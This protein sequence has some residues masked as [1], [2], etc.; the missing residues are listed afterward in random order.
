[1]PPRKKSPIHPTSCRGLHWTWYSCWRQL[2]ESQ[3]EFTV[4]CN[5]LC[6]L[7]FVF[8]KM[9][10][11]F[12]WHWFKMPPQIS[13]ETLD[14]S[15]LDSPSK[16]ATPRA[17]APDVSTCVIFERQGKCAEFSWCAVF[18]S[19]FCQ[20]FGTECWHHT[21]LK[22]WQTVSH[23]FQ[24]WNKFLDK[25]ARV[26]ACSFWEFIIYLMGEARTYYFWT[27]RVLR[28]I[29]VSF[30]SAWNLRW[31]F[32]SSRIT[33]AGSSRGRARLPVRWRMCS[34]TGK[35]LACWFSFLAGPGGTLFLPYLVC[36]CI[37]CHF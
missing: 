27:S 17:F 21:V 25:T 11:F 26:E 8:C 5:K 24:S 31:D 7:K 29:H 16:G 35:L 13:K 19:R 10:V 14:L 9:F 34:P 3:T 6:L 36:H 2:D 4:V 12:G 33:Q 1:M 23:N 18:C 30:S 22:M 37:Q 15:A 32:L 20:I 28:N